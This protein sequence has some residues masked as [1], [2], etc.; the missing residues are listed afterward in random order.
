MPA[1]S[2]AADPAAPAGIT[3]RATEL[4]LPIDVLI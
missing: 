2:F 3:G 1:E 4:G